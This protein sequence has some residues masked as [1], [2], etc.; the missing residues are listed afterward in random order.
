[1]VKLQARKA[2]AVA[3]TDA[4]SIWRSKPYFSQVVVRQRSAI[5]WKSRSSAGRAFAA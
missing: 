3:P 2:V 5:F 4:T 1:M